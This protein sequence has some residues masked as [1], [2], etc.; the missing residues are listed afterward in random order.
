MGEQARTNFWQLATENGTVVI[1]SGSSL[2]LIHR[3]THYPTRK[4][5]PQVYH[6]LK[7]IAHIPLAIYILLINNFSG[8]TNE[9]LEQY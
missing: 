3:G 9:A 5:I 4:A 7:S 1:G 8:S 2:S 6:D